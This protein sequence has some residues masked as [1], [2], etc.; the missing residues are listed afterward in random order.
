VD[1]QEGNDIA[2]SVKLLRCR[3]RDFDTELVFQRHDRLDDV[4]AGDA[5]LVH[6]R[7]LGDLVGIDLEFLRHDAADPFRHSVHRLS[8][9]PVG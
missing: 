5:Q 1:S 2:D 6:P 7:G 9:C 4:D 3:I 8:S